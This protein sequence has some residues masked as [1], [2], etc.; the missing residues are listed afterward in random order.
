MSQVVD[1]EKARREAAAKKGFRNW[2]SKFKEDFGLETRLSHI[3]IQTLGFLA[4]GHE[5]SA[6]YLNDLIMHLHSLGSGFEFRELT[7]NNKMRVM[8][9][10]L[11]LLDRIRFEYM[12]R[13]GWLK[14]YPGEE[15]PV[16]EMIL[17]FQDKASGIHEGVPEPDENH[18]V[19]KAFLAAD[20]LEKEVLVR[21]LIPEL[22]KV[23]E[24]R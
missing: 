6:F 4:L 10:Y 5:A 2:K 8:D 3:S 11:F 17:Q 14:R 24:R 1:L 16:V 20:A 23:I 19:H 9:Q 7:K 22:L 12:K 18:P 13:L 21:K 15:Y